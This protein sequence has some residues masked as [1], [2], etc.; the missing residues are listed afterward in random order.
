MR[1]E[2]W[3]C[4][5]VRV[6]TSIDAKAILFIGE[7]RFFF[8]SFS[9]LKWSVSWAV[10]VVLTH[11]FDRPCYFAY[12][13]ILSESQLFRRFFFGRLSSSSPKNKINL[14]SG[15][16]LDELTMWIVRS[17][18]PHA[19][20]RYGDEYL[21]NCKYFGVDRWIGMNLWMY[22]SHKNPINFSCQTPKV[23]HTE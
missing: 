14:Q 11:P 5:W 6:A 23:V 12:L 7:N 3:K 8:H 1:D 22:G 9:P 10:F 15:S 19:L 17:G 18:F 21:V 4:V 20:S 2:K 13:F 16:I